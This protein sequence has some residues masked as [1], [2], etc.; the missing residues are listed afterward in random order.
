MPVLS[1]KRLKYPEFLQKSKIGFP[2]QVFLTHHNRLHGFT[3]ST[4]NNAP[5]PTPE[6]FM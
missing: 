2:D 1:S 6:G 3:V 4:P 5:V